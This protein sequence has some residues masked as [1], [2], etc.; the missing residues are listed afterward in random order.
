MDIYNI[1]FAR[2]EIANSIKLRLLEQSNVEEIWKFNKSDL[3]YS[4]DKNNIRKINDKRNGITYVLLSSVLSNENK[5]Y[6]R[7]PVTPIQDSAEIS[8]KFIIVM[9][10]A[11]ITLGGIAITFNRRIK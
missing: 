6:I 4:Q 7:M 8:N 1:W 9:G 10:M 5:L 3:M 2:I 11:A